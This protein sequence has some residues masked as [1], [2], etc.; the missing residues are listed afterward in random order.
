[1]AE[2]TVERLTEFGESWNKSDPDLVASFFTDDGAFYSS[3]G[4]EPHGR[5]YLGRDGIR[6]AVRDFDERYPGGQFTNLEVFVSGD[7]G[8]LKWE[9]AVPDGNGGETRTVGCDLLELRGDLVHRKSAFQKR[10][11]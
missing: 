2:M 8:I 1:M 11:T 7:T 10:R 4:P 6:Q 5:S 9:L 3:A